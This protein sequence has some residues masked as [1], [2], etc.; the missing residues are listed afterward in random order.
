MIYERSFEKC[1]FVIIVMHLKITLT[2]KY[3]KESYFRVLYNLKVTLRKEIKN[4]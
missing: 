3:L 4:W 1:I 2:L